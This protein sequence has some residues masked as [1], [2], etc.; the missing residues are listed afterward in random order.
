[1]DVLA[2]RRH[3]LELLVA[4][5]RADGGTQKDAA[6]ALDLSP[7]YLSQLIGGKKMGDDVA[8]KVEVAQ[9]LPHGWMDH[10]QNGDP[11]HIRDQR[12]TTY[13]LSHRLRIEPEI[14]ASAIKLVRLSFKNLKLEFDNE[15]DGVPLAFAY[16]YLLDREQR[17][18]TAENLV[19]FS[20]KLAERLRKTTD[21]EAA[22]SDTG[23]LG[24]G[25]RG[26]GKGRKTG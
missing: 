11:S 20:E 21:D 9:K 5:L 8:R 13:G 23:R 3:N 24:R 6:L 2:I 19:D 14:I 25:D 26:T 17:L 4:Q 18:V 12:S 15:Q 10:L 22:E 7:S 16:E 1:M